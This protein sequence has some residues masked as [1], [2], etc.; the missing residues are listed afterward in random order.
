M[1]WAPK[2]RGKLKKIHKITVSCSIQQFTRQNINIGRFNNFLKFRE[3]LP[4]QKWIKYQKLEET[5]KRSTKSQF[6][7]IRHGTSVHVLQD[8]IYILIELTFFWST[9]SENLR[10]KKLI[11]KVSKRRGKFKKVDKITFFFNF[12]WHIGP[13]YKA[14]YSYWLSK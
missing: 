9:Y 4:G 12:T 11:N 1:N 2:R 5:S 10:G 3:N 14:K 6:C 8:K 7:S 13:I